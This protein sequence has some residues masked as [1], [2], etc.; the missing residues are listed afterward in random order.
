MC[1]ISLFVE[2]LPAAIRHA[3]ICVAMSYCESVICQFSVN[4]AGVV[5]TL[6]S[7]LSGKSIQHRLQDPIRS[8]LE[9][10]LERIFVCHCSASQAS[11]A[12]PSSQFSDPAGD[13][14]AEQDI[15]LKITSRATVHKHERRC[16]PLT[17]RLAWLVPNSE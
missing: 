16:P 9:F 8:E 11:Q 12:S 3:K 15:L 2:T 17:A 5:F 1:T 13:E 14:R 4:A 6:H 7:E 10:F